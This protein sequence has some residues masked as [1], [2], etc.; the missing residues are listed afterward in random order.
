MKNHKAR[1]SNAVAA[2][3]MSTAAGSA[4][5]IANKGQYQSQS[6]PSRMKYERAIE[7]NP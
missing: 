7:A 1:A 6:Q 3:P 4:E 2:A 5:Q